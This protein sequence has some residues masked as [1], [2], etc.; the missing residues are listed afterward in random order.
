METKSPSATGLSVPLSEANRSRSAPMYSST[1]SGVTS[2]LSTVTGIP[3]I[4]GMS[5]FGR[6]STSAVNAS[7]LPSSSLVTSTSGW[8]SANTSCSSSA[9]P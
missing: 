8:P 2:A 9:L 3:S 6:T 4:S 1:W 7:S 5:N